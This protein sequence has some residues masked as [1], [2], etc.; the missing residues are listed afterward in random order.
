MSLTGVYIQCIPFTRQGFSQ[1]SFKIMYDT[2]AHT[3]KV[4]I[5]NTEV[6][7]KRPTDA[8]LASV[9]D[10]TEARVNIMTEKKLVIKMIFI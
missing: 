10:R 2:S 5:Q 6:N 8:V 1:F 3:L 4:W 7:S 9:K